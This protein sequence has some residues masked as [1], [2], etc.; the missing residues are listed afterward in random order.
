MNQITNVLVQF[1][2]NNYKV[3]L[4]TLTYSYLITLIGRPFILHFKIPSPNRNFTT[5]QFNHV[6]AK[7]VRK[8]SVCEKKTEA[9]YRIYNMIE[10]KQSSLI[11]VTITYIQTY[12]KKDNKSRLISLCFST[13]LDLI[14]I[15]I[16]TSG[17]I[18]QETNYKVRD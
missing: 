5:L 3:N 7:L 4:I 2:D 13:Q 15:K 6:G 18:M 9:T 17:K 14:N 1:G 10:L 16:T 12:D 8:G 11:Y